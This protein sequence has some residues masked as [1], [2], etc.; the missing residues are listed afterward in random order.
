LTMYQKFASGGAFCCA[1]VLMAGCGSSKLFDIWSDASF[2]SPSLKKV[3]VISVSKNSVHRRLWEDTIITELAKHDVAGTPSYR[4]FPA[5]APDTN[6]VLDIVR[7]HEF[8]GVLVTRWLPKELKTQY[9]N[10]YMTTEPQIG[11]EGRAKR[12]VTYYRDIEHVGYIDSQKV[13]I[14]GIDVWSTKEEGHMIWS[15]TSKTP[16]PNLTQEVR[17]EIVRLVMNELTDRGIIASER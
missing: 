2:Q 12:F 16:E 17:P 15:A 3:L 9:L 7:S 4:P 14:R 11:Y 6:Q 10:G 1:L 13:D 5:L 8:E